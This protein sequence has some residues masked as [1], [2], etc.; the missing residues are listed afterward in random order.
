M[1]VAKVH[2]LNVTSAD[3]VDRFLSLLSEAIASG[4]GHLASLKKPF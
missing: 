2:V 4:R 3:P 1:A